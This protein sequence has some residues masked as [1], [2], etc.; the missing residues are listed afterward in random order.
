MKCP[1][2]RFKGCLLV[3]ISLAHQPI[4]CA[5]YVSYH[6]KL[7][8]RKHVPQSAFDLLMQTRNQL[9]SWMTV[10]S[11]V[12][13]KVLDGDTLMAATKTLTQIPPAINMLLRSA[14]IQ[15]AFRCGDVDSFN[16]V[17]LQYFEGDEDVLQRFGF[18][19]ISS[20]GFVDVLV[21]EIF[22]EKHARRAEVSA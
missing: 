6:I 1:D 8:K 5:G 4:T 19:N 22:S 16:E 12:Q 9:K 2:N 20:M 18:G 10:L 3:S 15:E 7:T 17:L 21:P 13:E 14:R 11:T